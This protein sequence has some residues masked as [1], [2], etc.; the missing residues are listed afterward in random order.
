MISFKSCEK[1]LNEFLKKC[2]TQ[3]EAARFLSEDMISLL[4]QSSL[5]GKV[6]YIKNDIVIKEVNNELIYK[7]LKDGFNELIK[8]TNTAEIRIFQTFEDLPAIIKCA[9]TPEKF[10]KFMEII[11]KLRDHI[12]SDIEEI[13]QKVKKE[14]L[15]KD[16]LPATINSVSIYFGKTLAYPVANVNVNTESVLDPRFA[17]FTEECRALQPILDNGDSNAFRE[18]LIPKIPEKI[19]NSLDYKSNSEYYAKKR[20]ADKIHEMECKKAQEAK[21]KVLQMMGINSLSGPGF[22][23]TSP[24]DTIKTSQHYHVM[25]NKGAKG[26]LVQKVSELLK[27]EKNLPTINLIF[28]QIKTKKSALTQIINDHELVISQGFGK[29][30]PATEEEIAEIKRSLPKPLA[31]KATPGTSPFSGVLKH[32]SGT[33]PA[34]VIEE[35]RTL[36]SDIRNFNSASLK[37]TSSTK[38]EEL[39]HQHLPATT[40]KIRTQERGG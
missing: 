36:L 34:K 15:K 33:H 39:A 25:T 28:E 9:D 11:A 35:P 6:T 10:N 2:H 3:D 22:N 13:N 16:R 40:S 5:L 38:K 37:P 26:D 17:Q 24:S 29:R 4:N 19:I 12:S 30:R 8:S 21:T 14:Q 23:F 18:W 20:E 32:V 31:I 1:H 7:D 27:D